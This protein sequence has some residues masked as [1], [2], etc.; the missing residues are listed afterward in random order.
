MD[1]QIDRD[2]RELG[3]QWRASQR[4]APEVDLA[5]LSSRGRSGDLWPFAAVGTL[6]GIALIVGGILLGPSLL[7]GGGDESA[8]T[9]T[10]GT[11]NCSPTRPDPPFDPPESYPQYPTAGKQKVWFGSASL[12]T[13]LNRDGE[14]WGPTIAPPHTIEVKTFWWSADWSPNEEPEPRITVVGA[15]LD[16]PGTFSFGPGTNAGAGFGTAM[17][18]G[19]EVPNAGCWRITANYRRASLSYVVLAVDQ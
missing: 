6:G 13:M 5:A 18:V 16:G 12:W 2:L 15:Q 8:P 3:E 11:A 17:L 14:V 7:R 1:E 19:I 9:A 4:P 10:T